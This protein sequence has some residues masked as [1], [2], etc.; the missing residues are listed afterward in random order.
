LGSVG[1]NAL[2]ADRPTLCGGCPGELICVWEEFDSMNVEP[3]TGLLRAVVRAARSL[4]NG[5][6]WSYAV[7]LTVPSLSSQRFPCV[8]P[9]IWHDSLYFVRYMTDEVAGFGSG[10]YG[11]GP[12]TNNPIIVQSE[13]KSGFPMPG[14]AEAP[15]TNPIRHTISA[16]P[17][18]FRGR[19]VIS[20]DLPKAG[21]ISLRVCDAAG[22]IVRTLVKVRL[23]PG[24]YTVNWDG[25]AE[26]GAPALPGIYFLNLTALGGFETRKLVLT[27]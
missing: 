10:P 19:T 6:H 18:P 25:R 16:S 21:W 2:Y 24:R 5:L 9:R 27:R 11:Q 15:P 12:I 4:D 1:Y 22:R 20:Y 23:E 14:V 7:C 8:A 17:N 3:A 26:N 13:F